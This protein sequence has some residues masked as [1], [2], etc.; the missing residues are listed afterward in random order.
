MLDFIAAGANAPFTFSLVL[1]VLITA[2]EFIGLL[3]GLGF[4]QFF[5]N[6]LPDVE[7]PGEL[8]MDADAHVPTLS[9]VLTWLRVG[10][11]PILILL[12]VFLTVFGLFGLGLQSMWSAFVGALMPRSIAV[13]L[14]LCA[15]IPCFRVVSGLLVRIAPRDE[16]SAVSD[17]TFIGR[18]ATITLG[19]AAKNSPAEARLEDQYGQTHYIMVVPDNEG[20]S[21]SQG[22]QVLVVQKKQPVFT[23]IAAA[24]SLLTD[25]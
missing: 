17:T 8:G 5:D 3:L 22:E 10:Q 25:S 12:I 19:V 4:S 24:H 9:V 21:F 2:L 18:V 11:M 23:V 6:L 14:A 15:T 13:V 16:T 20:D 1:M 7:A